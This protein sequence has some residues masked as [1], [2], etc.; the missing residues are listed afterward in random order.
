MI[1]RNIK[2]GVTVDVKS[3]VEGDWE[4]VSVA[5]AVEEKPVKKEIKKAKKKEE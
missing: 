5:S 2:T 3:K 4:L 1:Y